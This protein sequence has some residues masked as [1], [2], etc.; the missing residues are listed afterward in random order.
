[1]EQKQ[2]V[3]FGTKT[4]L[5]LGEEYLTEQGKRYYSFIKKYITEQNRANSY[6]YRSYHYAKQYTR[7][8]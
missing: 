2:L 5:K 6:Y 1:M 3:Q 7:K 4:T 8:I